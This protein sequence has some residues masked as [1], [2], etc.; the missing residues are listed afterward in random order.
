MNWADV[1]K[2]VTGKGDEPKE[3]KGWFTVAMS[4]E[5]VRLTMIKDQLHEQDIGNQRNL[6]KCA[7][8]ILAIQ[9]VIQKHERD[10]RICARTQ[11]PKIE[12]AIRDAR[13]DLLHWEGWLQ[14]H[15]KIEASIAAKKKGFPEK[16][17]QKLLR[18]QKEW[19]HDRMRVHESSE[20]ATKIKQGETQ[21]AIH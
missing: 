15:R 11:R 19:P 4:D 17:F 8:Q 2:K 20:E 16:R 9:D 3:K 6:S 1:W 18:W 13:G 10:Q 5:L 14:Q 21:N 12:E 7:R